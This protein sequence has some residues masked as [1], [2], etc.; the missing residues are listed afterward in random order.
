MMPPMKDPETVAKQMRKALYYTN[1]SLEPKL[2][3][4]YYREGLHVA[5]VAA[6]RGSDVSYE[7]AYFDMEPKKATRPKP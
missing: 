4:K 5:D 6:D 1:Q 7:D 2:A 3:V